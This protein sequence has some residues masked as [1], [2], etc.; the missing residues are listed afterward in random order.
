[1]RLVLFTWFPLAL[2]SQS[3]SLRQGLTILDQ[4]FDKDTSLRGPCDL[5]LLTHIEES[6]YDGYRAYYALSSAN[7]ILNLRKHLAKSESHCLIIVA[8]G[9]LK[10]EHLM[11]HVQQIQM[12]RPVAVLII[13][14]PKWLKDTTISPTLD[15]SFPVFILHTDFSGNF[16][17]ISTNM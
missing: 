14:N 9:K 15:F 17:N 7:A 3:F 4:S 2:C 1:M 8:S 11:H 16:T 12:I 10:W 6:Q 13:E 5:I